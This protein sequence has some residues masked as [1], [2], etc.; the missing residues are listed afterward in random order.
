VVED[1]QCLCPVGTVWIGHRAP[2]ALEEEPLP[3]D[4]GAQ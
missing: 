2:E 3:V 4:V 1:G